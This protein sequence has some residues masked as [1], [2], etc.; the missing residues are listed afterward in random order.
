[1]P[2][3]IP[4]EEQA[5]GT[6]RS[7]RRLVMIACLLAQFMAAVEGTIVSTAMPSIVGELGGF[8]LFSWVFAAYLLAQAITSPIY[9]RLADLFGRKRVFSAGAILFLAGSAA[10][11]LASGMVPLIVFRL[12]QGIGSGAIQPVAW[13]VVGDIY[14]PQERARVQGYLSAVFGCSAIAGPMLGGF[15]VEHLHWSL[16]FWIN[17]PVGIAAM[18]M[19]G[20]FLKERVEPRRPRIDYLGAVLLSLGLG[21]ILVVIVQA[22]SLDA[23][24]IAILSAVGVVALAVLAFYE[25][26]VTEPIVPFNLWRTPIVTIGNFGSFTIGALMICNGA[27]LPTYVQG[28][29]GA[30]PA[31]AGLALG[32]SSLLWTCGTFSGGRLM[33]AT[34]YR[35]TGVFGG[36]IM[37]IGSAVMIALEPARGPLWAAAGSAILGLGMGFTNTTFVIAVQ[38]SVGWG[39]RGAVTA[40]NL[41]MRTLGQSVGAGFF[42]AVFNFEMARSIAG[43][44]DAM[45]NRLLQPELRE[46]LGSERIAALSNAIAGSM[47]TVYLLAAIVA[48]IIL[49]LA[50]RVPAGLSPIRHAERAGSGSAMPRR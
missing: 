39:E 50:A 31:V 12:I 42:G 28:A 49:A 22:R 38:S 17:I 43:D 13:T 33:L 48:V 34:S 18:L 20:T 7:Q 37:L 44:S 15:I 41:F 2:D 45:I 19:L 35:A 1:M 3:N 40:A 30:S 47:H 6:P 32:A 4:I 9:G 46:S 25:R 29:M 16:V 11:G 27:F 14:T 24:A 21:S 8:R 36:V 23:T 5:V 26:R 10:C